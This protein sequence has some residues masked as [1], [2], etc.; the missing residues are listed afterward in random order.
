MRHSLTYVISTIVIFLFLSCTSG[1]NDK[2]V[3]E[4]EPDV[5]QVTQQDAGMNAAIQT[6]KDSFPTFL[7]AI[8]DN[9]SSE[10][11]S[12][13]I[14]LRFDSPEGGE[15]IWL[16]D[17]KMS[18]SKLIGIVANEPVS[19]NDVQLGDTVEVVLANLSDWMYMDRHKMQGAF[20]VR[21]LRKRMSDVERSDFDLETDNVFR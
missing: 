7:A 15:H 19:T 4:G 8:R 14:K 5:V 6:A 20:T 11:Y 13:Q 18:E 10:F 1:K 16:E 9:D 2:I 17:I 3:R 21:E 12:F